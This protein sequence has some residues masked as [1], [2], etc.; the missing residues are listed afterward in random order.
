VLLAKTTGCTL[1]GITERGYHYPRKGVA[2]AGLFP[3]SLADCK[4]HR[5]GQVLIEQDSLALLLRLR[6]RK[7]LGGR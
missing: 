3:A 5:R 7:S 2:R 6:L 1:Q 4:S